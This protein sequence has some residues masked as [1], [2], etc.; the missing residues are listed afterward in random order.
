MNIEIES[1]HDDENNNEIIEESGK[2]F[3]MN[4]NEFLYR[5]ISMKM[6]EENLYTTNDDNL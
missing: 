3:M 1:D 2:N 5:N 6:I 4:N